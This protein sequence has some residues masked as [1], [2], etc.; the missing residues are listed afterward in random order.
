MDF[1]QKKAEAGTGTLIMFIAMI[2]VAAIAAG[3]FMQTAGSLQNKALLTGN[4]VK[5][6]VSSRAEVMNSRR[7]DS[8]NDTLT[9]YNVKMRL[10]PGSDGISLKKTLISIEGTHDSIDLTYSPGSCTNDPNSGYYADAINRNG[11]FTVNYLIKSNSQADGYF[12]GGDIIQLC[13]AYAKISE[14]DRVYSISFVPPNGQQTRIRG[15]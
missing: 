12:L 2:L 14:D 7:V 8:T 4:E 10:A 9:E 11:S 5:E 13:F 3:V 1:V 6:L 15:R